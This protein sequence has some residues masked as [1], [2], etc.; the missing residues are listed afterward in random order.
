MEFYMF[1]TFFECWSES[2]VVYL[3]WREHIRQNVAMFC[4]EIHK[5][6]AFDHAIV[7]LALFHSLSSEGPLKLRVGGE[8][9]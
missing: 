7:E 4:S 2:W 3:L 5:Q 8:Q 1:T 6:V 9:I